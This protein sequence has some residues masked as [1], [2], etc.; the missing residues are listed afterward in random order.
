MV[1]AP[2]ENGMQLVRLSM[3][4]FVSRCLMV[5]GVG[6]AQANRL[7]EKLWALHI[8]SRRTEI[9]KVK[10]AQDQDRVATNQTPDIPFNQRLR[11]GMFVRARRSKIDGGKDDFRIVMIMCPE[12]SMSKVSGTYAKGSRNGTADKVRLICAAVTPTTVHGAY[13]VNVQRHIVV[14]V[15]DMKEEL[16][17]EYDSATRYH[18]LTA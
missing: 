3:D 17:V 18:F 12:G 16:A 15:E 11:P 14:A 5:Q 6:H 13:E 7:Y 2:V 4:E 8:D 1:L 9:S 10:P